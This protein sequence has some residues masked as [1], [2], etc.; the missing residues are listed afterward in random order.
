MSAPRWQR[1]TKHDSVQH[2]SSNELATV[3][4][5]LSRRTVASVNKRETD[6]RVGKKRN[7][8]V[9]RRIKRKKSARSQ[10]PGR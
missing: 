2:A 5:E 9:Q 3:E 1:Y 10:G 6:K 4:S 8:A 7:F